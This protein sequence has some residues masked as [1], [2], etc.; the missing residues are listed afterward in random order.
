M[1]TSI[2]V[3]RSAAVLAAAGAAAAMTLVPAGGANAAVAGMYGSFG[4]AS[5]DYTG[6][7]P[8]GTCN[9]VTP[10]SDSPES[11]VQNFTHGTRH[12]SVALDASYTSST[13]AADTTRI[14]GRI[15]STLTLKRHLGDL[16][17]FALAA[18]GKASVHHSVAGSECAV[19]GGLAAAM[20][21]TFTEHKKGYLSL[22]RDTTKPNSLVTFI[23]VNT[24]TGKPVSFSLFEGAASH[25]TSRALL[26]PGTYVIAQ[27]QAGISVGGTGLLFKSASRVT[28]PSFNIHLKGT[29]KPLKK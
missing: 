28:K 20:Q 16:T 11:V 4:S 12:S 18:G 5:A 15:D 26:K 22:T 10:G 27:S 14:Q 19:T 8:A 3:R 17:S 6:A 24:K 21:V 1:S 9:L 23:L 29:F 2:F 25:E 13:N 7:D